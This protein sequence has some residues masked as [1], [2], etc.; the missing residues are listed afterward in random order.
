MIPELFALGSIPI[1]SFGLM[2]A[3]SLVASSYLLAKSFK[4][5]GID[6]QKAEIFVFS[7]GF[8]GLLGARLWYLT[9]HIDEVIA[10]PVS[11][12]FSS[13][14]FVFYGGF[15]FALLVL[16][17]LAKKHHVRFVDFLDAAG[18][19]MLLGY[20]IGRLGCQLSGDGDYGIFTESILGMSYLTGVVPTAKGILAYPTPIF[21]ST[22]SLIALWLLLKTET[23]TFWHLP[24][25]RFGFFLILMGVERFFIEFIRLNPKILWGLSEAQFVSFA[26]VG[27]GFVLIFGGAVFGAASIKR[28]PVGAL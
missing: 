5:Y 18:P 11:T 10:D 3:A 6:S 7:A 28:A 8:S 25:R 4:I 14:G 15:I 20:A 27:I 26:M 12:I 9:K 19:S 16:F 2:I 1:N 17:F 21:E 24:L 22:F 23:K 13:A